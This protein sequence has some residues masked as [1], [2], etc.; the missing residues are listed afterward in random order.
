MIQ[1]IPFIKYS[2]CGNA[3]IIVDETERPWI[4]EPEKKRF[5]ARAAN[6]FFGLGADGVIF[7][8]PNHPE[9]I[10]AIHENFPYWRNPPD[11]DGAGLVLRMFEPDG[12]ESFSCGNGLLS[13]ANHLFHQ[14]GITRAE[15]VTEIPTAQPRK[16]A[17]GTDPERGVNW[18]NM[19][20]PERFPEGMVNPDITLGHDTVMDRVPG[21]DIAGRTDTA[22]NDPQENPA[23]R[24]KGFLVY[25]GEPHFVIIADQLSWATGAPHLPSLYIPAI[26][27]H[28]FHFDLRF[29]A[30]SRYIRHIG[31]YLNTE[32]SVFFPRGVNIDFVR[33]N[34]PDSIE[35]RCFE[36]GV[37]RET[38]SCGTGAVA[39]FAAARQLN[40]IQ[41]DRISVLPH[42][43]RLFNPSAGFIVQKTDTGC[44]LFGEPRIVSRGLLCHQPLD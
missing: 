34:G 20:M 22:L 10:H 18:V 2:S 26:P 43:C 3:F 37:N 35:Y 4:R 29:H 31:R 19:G 7:I 27:D 32:G 16:V 42:L 17:I 36:R 14:Y 8:Q 38:L 13:I 33:V 25:T 28:A 24:V 6:I 12:S 5:A 21:L 11:L 40:L 1:D 15:I 30:S 39:C 23:A 9:V 44:H 41:S